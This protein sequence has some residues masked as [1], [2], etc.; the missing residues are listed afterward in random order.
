VRALGALDASRR[1]RPVGVDSNDCTRTAYRAIR[2]RRTRRWLRFWEPHELP[3]SRGRRRS[4]GDCRGIPSHLRRLAPTVHGHVPSAWCSSCATWKSSSSSRSRARARF[5]WPRSNAGSGARQQRFA[6]GRARDD[7]LRG[8]LE[9]GGRWAKLSRRLDELGDAVAE[10]SERTAR[11]GRSPRLGGISCRTDAKPGP[12]A[13]APGAHR[14][15]KRCAL[16]AS[17]SS[18]MWACGSSDHDVRG[19]EP[20]V[21]GRS[22]NGCS[23]RRSAAPSP[24]LGRQRAEPR[25]APACASP[26]PRPTVRSCLVEQGKLHAEIRHVEPEHVV[27]AA[28]GPFAVHVTGTR[29]DAGWSRQA[30]R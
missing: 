15:R 22:A 14:G 18:P 29:F 23:R 30:R 9:E 12:G 24:L 4:S 19:R 8:W 17:C 25:P 26:R 6:R 27:E 11:P 16:R 13:P 10:V 20:A 1:G 21:P 3:E 5:P 2:T 7:V 28:G